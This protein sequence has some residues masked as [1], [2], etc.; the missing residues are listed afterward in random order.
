MLPP[1]VETL[2]WARRNNLVNSTVF[3]DDRFF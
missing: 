2:P 1:L 3:F